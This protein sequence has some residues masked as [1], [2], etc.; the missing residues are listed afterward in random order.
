MRPRMAGVILSAALLAAPAVAQDRNAKTEMYRSLVEASRKLPAY[1]DARYIDLNENE[2]GIRRVYITYKDTNKN[3]EIDTGDI[4]ELEVLY[5]P[6]R[7]QPY[8]VENFRGRLNSPV[9]YHADYHDKERG[10][11][12]T[13]SIVPLMSKAEQSKVL[14]RHKNT[15][16]LLLKNIR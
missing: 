12:C 13:E 2:K 4:L 7:E 6:S 3:G 15:V 14:T 10:E 8:I 11:V 5:N 1:R 9:F 16:T